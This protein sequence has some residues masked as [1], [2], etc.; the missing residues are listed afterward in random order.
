MK[1][2]FLDDDTA[3]I[4]RVNLII[5]ADIDVTI[6]STAAECIDRLKEAEDWDLICLDHDLGGQVFVNSSREDCGMEVVRYL[7]Q[8]PERHTASKIL[9]HSWNGYA[10]NAMRLSLKTSGY[11]VDYEPFTGKRDFIRKHAKKGG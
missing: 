10:G 3:R 7:M 4:Q 8:Y 11:D 9:V 6:V 5:D 2:L 1:V